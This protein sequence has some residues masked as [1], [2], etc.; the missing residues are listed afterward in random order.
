MNF[1]LF[2]KGSFPF[3]PRLIPLLADRANRWGSQRK[4]QR[5]SN[6]S[7]A[8]W[9]RP[10]L[11]GVW[12]PNLMTPS[13]SQRSYPG[14]LSAMRS[15]A[16][17]VTLI[18]RGRKW[19]NEEWGLTLCIVVP[20]D[21]VASA[22]LSFAVVANRNLLAYIVLHNT[23]VASVQ[24]HTLPEKGDIKKMNCSIILLKLPFDIFT[25]M[26]TKTD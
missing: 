25:P 20:K 9:C 19:T 22:P 13:W 1:C 4:S 2:D 17:D 12:S 6:S 14:G 7:S 26:I 10:L 18:W 21:F 5:R 11:S 15:W 23:S 24:L 8:R 16:V 3:F